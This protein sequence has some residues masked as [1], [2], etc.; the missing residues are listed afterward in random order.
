MTAPIRAPEVDVQVVASVPDHEVE[1]AVVRRLRRVLPAALAPV[2]GDPGGRRR[3][4]TWVEH[5]APDVVQR[6]RGRDIGPVGSEGLVEVARGDA[7]GGLECLLPA[8][9]A[10]QL[11]VVVEQSALAGVFCE[12]LAR[13]EREAPRLRAAAVRVLPALDVGEL[14]RRAPREPDLGLADGGE[15]RRSGGDLVGV[16]RVALDREAQPERPP[17]VAPVRQL[18]QRVPRGEAVADVFEVRAPEG[19]GPRLVALRRDDHRP[20]ARLR[21]EVLRDLFREDPRVDR[22]ERVPPPDVDRPVHRPP[23]EALCEEAAERREAGAD[24]L[25]GRGRHLAHGDEDGIEAVV[26]EVRERRSD[27]GAVR[28]ERVVEV[29]RGDAE[30]GLEGL[31]PRALHG[32]IPEEVDHPLLG[33]AV[34]Q[35][36]NGDE[37]QA[38]AGTTVRVERGGLL[39][40]LEGGQIARGQDGQ[41]AREVSVEVLGHRFL[42]GGDS[43]EQLPRPGGGSLDHPARHGHAPVAAQGL[44]ERVEVLVRVGARADASDPSED[45]AAAVVRAQI[46]GRPAADLHVLRGQR[47][48]ITYLACERRF[49]GPAFG[50]DS[51]RPVHPA[52]DLG[53]LRLRDL[54]HEHDR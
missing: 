21:A 1:G 43:Q 6:V 52:A 23:A 41:I 36:I 49:D 30:R 22:C 32:Q 11:P 45:H 9:R 5:D 18:R 40:L 44:L 4:A 46:S 48:D 14:E 7:E 15:L 8:R 10:G 26:G 24:G 42:V 33:G 25:R 19:G 34:D 37:S 54:A 29:A 35:P 16:L 2:G 12:P 51:P 31:V 3:E 17:P 28:L 38:V 39:H 13:E 50:V 47:F 53:L 27:L 20:T